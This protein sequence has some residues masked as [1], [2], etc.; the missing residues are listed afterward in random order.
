MAFWKR[1]ADKPTASSDPP[2]RP[3]PPLLP[4]VEQLAELIPERNRQDNFLW[5]EYVDRITR[6]FDGLPAPD[7]NGKPFVRA[8]LAAGCE[9]ITGHAGERHVE[10]QAAGPVGHG[11]TTETPSRRASASRCSSPC[12]LR[13]LAHTLCRLRIKMGR[14]EDWHV[15]EDMLR[16]GE[17]YWR[18]LFGG[19]VTFRELEE[20][21]RRQDRRHVA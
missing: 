13:Y 18:P 6:R 15:F 5:Q 9:A 19:G 21:S 4:E 17:I 20:A 7:R 16:V 12:S 11:G 2:P 14:V 1:S 10:E 8:C 3:D